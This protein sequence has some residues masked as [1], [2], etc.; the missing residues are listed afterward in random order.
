M[1]YSINELLLLAIVWAMAHFKNYVYGVKFKLTSGHK[2]NV[3]TYI[4]QR[5]QNIFHEINKM[6]R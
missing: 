3:S 1:K 6:S 4:E 5:K 2:R